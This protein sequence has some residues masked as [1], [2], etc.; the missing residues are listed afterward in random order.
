LTTI[1]EKTGTVPEGGSDIP[2]HY[3]PEKTQSMP[4]TIQGTWDAS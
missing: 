4:W 3:R 2:I 1:T